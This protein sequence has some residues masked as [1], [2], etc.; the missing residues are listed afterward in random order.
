MIRLSKMTDYAS[1]VLT[2]LAV[3]APTLQS[4][5]C[6]AN[7]TRIPKPTVTKLLKLLTKAGLTH[8]VQGPRGGYQL[9]RSARQ[10]DL[11]DIIGAIEG[12]SGVTECVTDHD[13]CDLT[14][15]C[16]VMDHWHRVSVQINQLLRSVTLAEL[17]T[18]KL[19]RIPT[20]QV[21]DDY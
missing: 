9:A 16:H 1:V 10:I 3:D 15:H 18:P 19:Q 11:A 12:P 5:V 7:A 17:A 6:L 14:D 13:L 8:S 21:N 4:A 2:R 20:L